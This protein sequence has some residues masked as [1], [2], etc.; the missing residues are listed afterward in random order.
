MVA[1]SE[2]RVRA[3]LRPLPHFL[4]PSGELD[5]ATAPTVF[6]TGTMRHGAHVTVDLSRTTFIDAFALGA[7]VALR[8]TLTAAGGSLRLT[9]LTPCPTQLFRIGGLTTLLETTSQQQ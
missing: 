7:I 1:A 8:H 3:D 4:H 6:T 9:G 5:V 2:R